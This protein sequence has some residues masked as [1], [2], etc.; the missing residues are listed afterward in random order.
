MSANSLRRDHIGEGE[1]IFTAARGALAMAS[2]TRVNEWRLKVPDNSSLTRVDV[3]YG[4]APSSSRLFKMKVW[5]LAS[6]NVASQFVAKG[7]C[8]ATMAGTSVLS[9]P[10]KVLSTVTLPAGSVLAFSMVTG[11]PTSTAGVRLA[12]YLTKGFAQA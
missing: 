4:T 1:P 7:Y 8:Q 11:N 6:G 9:F 5:S 2:A 12:V 10:L 3:M